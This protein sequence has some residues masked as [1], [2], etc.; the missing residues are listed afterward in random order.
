MSSK[1]ETVGEKKEKNS[2]LSKIPTSEKQN[3]KI[4]P[5]ETQSSSI[6]EISPT[7]D[8]IQKDFGQG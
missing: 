8:R 4:D 1:V 3:T 6:D 2:T 5:A 7:I